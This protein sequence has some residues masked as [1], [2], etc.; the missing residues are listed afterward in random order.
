[1]DERIMN[2]V[3]LITDQLQTKQDL[4]SNEGKIMASLM[5]SGYRLH[6][7]DAA[8]TL[9][10]ALSQN[11]EDRLPNKGP[12]ALPDAMRSMNTEERSRFTIEAFGFITKLSCLGIISGEQREELLDKALSLHSGRIELSH[13]KSLLALDLFADEQEYEDILASALN[14]KGTVWN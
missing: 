14:H 6:E 11:E 4:F 10:Q 2:L 7:A 12:V 5:S 1:M 8:L 13:M 3:S 9:M